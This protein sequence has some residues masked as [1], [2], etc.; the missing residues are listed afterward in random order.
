MGSKSRDKGHKAGPTPVPPRSPLIDDDAIA[1]IRDGRVDALVFSGQQ[2]DQIFTLSGSENGYRLFVESMSEGAAT[3][4]ADGTI[5]YCN[6]R[7]AELAGRPLEKV[8]GSSVH[9]LF[10]PEERDVFTGAL[11]MAKSSSAKVELHLDDGVGRRVPVL[12]SVREFREF[13]SRA[14]CMVVTDLTEQKRH[15][16]LVSAGELSRTIL[17]Q[18]AQAIAVCDIE[19]RIILCSRALEDLCGR[20]PVL[21]FFDEALPLELQ[22]DASG[23]GETKPFSV[24]D[25]LS[26]QEFR[27]VEAKLRRPGKEAALFLLTAKSIPLPNTRGKGVVVTLFDIQERKRSEEALRKTERLA[28]TGRLAAVIAHEIN[29]PL[30]SITNLLYLIQVDPSLDGHLSHY[31]QLA[32]SELNRVA[33]I[34]KQTLAF[35]RESNEP[36]RFDVASLIESVIYLCTPRAREK[37]ADLVQDIRYHGDLYG[38]PNELRQVLA[39]IISN[40]LEACPRRGRV[41]L[42]VRRGTEFAGS[43]RQGVRLVIGDTGPGIPLRDRHR[44]FEPFYTTKGEKGTGLGL[45]VSL[46]II[47][48]HNGSIRMWSSTR[49]TKSGTVFSVFLPDVPEG[50]TIEW[51]S[52]P[53]PPPHQKKAKVG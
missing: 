46:G 14:L 41:W 3:L 4:A 43:L 10:S 6:R 40:A 8:M 38:H 52:T 7:M 9:L 18:S 47:Q 2:G 5:L 20:N 32:Q 23:A 25:V 12:I 15:E 34:T 29:N 39:N 35:H 21:Q 50:R 1:A 27:A 28:A 13:G 48:K 37:E 53:T 30:E 17:E 45:W 24:A 11:E 33:H 44:I 16:E 36:A 42:R 49:P 51:P 26:G 19:G 22:L 31:V